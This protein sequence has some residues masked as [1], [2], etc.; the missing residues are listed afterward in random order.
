[1]KNILI[2][3]LALGLASCG[4]KSSKVTKIDQGDSK[5]SDEVVDMTTPDTRSENEI[6]TNNTATD[7]ETGE[8]EVVTVVADIEPFIK[9]FQ[10]EEK[11]ET[12]LYHCKLRT[13]FTDG[14]DTQED[15]VLISFKNKSIFGK[16]RRAK[17]FFRTLDL[18][19]T[20][21]VKRGKKTK[22]FKVKT[23]VSKEDFSEGV[24]DKGEEGII[25]SLGENTIKVGEGFDE[26]KGQDYIDTLDAHWVGFPQ[27]EKNQKSTTK[28]QCFESSLK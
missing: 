19:N 20:K 10:K 24:N 18:E 17:I 26:E 28:V 3:L 14:R 2:V 1:M 11:D 7:A 16:R 15:Y 23:K 9:K 27:F 6:D 22:T 8:K 4:N 5:V 13:D 12:Y 21:F 25:L